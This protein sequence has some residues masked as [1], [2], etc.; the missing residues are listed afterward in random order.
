MGKSRP[1]CL[2]NKAEVLTGRKVDVRLMIESCQAKSRPV[3]QHGWSN[4]QKNGMYLPKGR[5]V[6]LK[7]KTGNCSFLA[8]KVDVFTKEVDFEKVNLWNNNG[9]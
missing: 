7:K 5:P 9:K 6:Y 2:E 4:C 3:Y 8:I 1:V